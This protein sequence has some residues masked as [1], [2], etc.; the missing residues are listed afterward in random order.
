MENINGM[1][2]EC[3]LKYFYDDIEIIYNFEWWVYL[4]NLEFGLDIDICII[5]IFFIK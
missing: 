1:L 4:K 5:L 3:K 2:K